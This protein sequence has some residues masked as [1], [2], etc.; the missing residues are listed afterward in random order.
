MR[1]VLRILAPA[2]LF[3]ILL[4]PAGA[5]TAAT[6]RV[7]SFSFTVDDCEGGTIRGEGS[8]QA[9][10]E[11]QPDWSISVQGDAQGTA[12]GS[13]GNE[14]VFDESHSE[15][16][17]FGDYTF[18]YRAQLI[19]QGSAPDEVLLVHYGLDSGLTFETDCSD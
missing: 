2:P 10:Y 6:E 12:V 1:A 5:A 15:E 4:V 14:Y 11:I 3:L 8:L 18:D 16:F 13:N 17:A 7:E 19:G 9:D